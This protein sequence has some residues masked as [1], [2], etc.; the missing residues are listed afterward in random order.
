M[1]VAFHAPMKPP[2]HPLPSGDRRMAQLLVAALAAGGHAVEVTS[3]L[4]TYLP[5]PEP[6]AQSSVQFEAERERERITASWA[7]GGTPPDVWFTYH[8]YHKA[9]DLLG[10]ALA[11]RFGLPY[12]L[13]EASLA[14][15]R[16][17]TWGSWFDA[18]RASIGAAD[19]H[20]CFTE[21]DR[22]GILPVVKTSAQLI[23]LPPFID[24]RA[25]PPAR[26]RQPTREPML[27]TVAMMRPGDKVRS[28]A[29]LA[30]ALEAIQD[31][32]WRLTV[33]G[34][35]PARREVEAL[36][37]PIDPARLRW[38]GALSAED[39]CRELDGADLYVWPGLGEAFGVSYLEAQAAG[40]PVAALDTAGV[41]SAVRDGITGLLATEPSAESFAA[42]LRR[43]CVDARLRGT[44]GRAASDWIRRERSLDDATRILS[45]ALTVAIETRR[46]DV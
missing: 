27:V 14:R 12:V 3:K 6:A 2:D 15:K 26:E 45:R 31:C 22:S 44:M 5:S 20:L 38:T 25:I 28:F 8:T 35:G 21:R 33:V 41:S 34:D 43:L 4:R 46:A 39:V 29:L 40:L 1:N 11:R 10:P 32:P 9:P 23:D 18:A 13:A 16:A 30:A 36:F 42:V 37:A 17:D 7:R 19:V 24:V